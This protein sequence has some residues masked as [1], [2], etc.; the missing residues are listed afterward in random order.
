[1]SNMLFQKFA[2]V[3]PSW[4]CL[5][6]IICKMMFF[7]LIIFHPWLYCFKVLLPSQVMRKDVIT[8]GRAFFRWTPYSWSYSVYDV[9]YAAFTRNQADRRWQTEDIRWKSNW[10]E[11][12]TLHYL[13]QIEYNVLL[14]CIT[15]C[16]CSYKCCCK[17][18]LKI[19]V[20]LQII[21]TCPSWLESQILLLNICIC[22]EKSA[23]LWPLGAT[24]TVC[25]PSYSFILPSYSIFSWTW[26]YF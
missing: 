25:L 19:I 16:N 17:I 13:K 10:T 7:G 18:L 1:M 11:G 20:K 15:A 22:Q 23:T 6:P 21:H 4:S 9:P 2:D 26:L 24:Y 8:W 12:R 14:L 3:F 5:A